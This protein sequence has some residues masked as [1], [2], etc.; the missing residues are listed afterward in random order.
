VTLARPTKETIG[1]SAAALLVVGLLGWWGFLY[2]GYAM[3]TRLDF[4][5]AYMFYR[6]A[7]HMR[8]GLGVS[9]NPDGVHTYGQTA[10]LWGLVVAGLSYLPLGMGEVLKMG[11]GASSILATVA[12]AWATAANATSP[13]IRRLAWYCCP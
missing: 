10:P 7:L 13:A 5:D 4:D 1:W 8:E 3:H 9:W 12:I 11:S 2:L 6:Y